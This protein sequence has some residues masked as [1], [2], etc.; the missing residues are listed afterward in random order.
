MRWEALFGD[1]EAQFEDAARDL[2]DDLVVDL[3]EAEMARAALSDRLR[4]RRGHPLTIRLVDGSDVRGVV[5]DAAPQWLLV[6]EGQR[7]V[8]VPL[9][10]VVAAWPL[11]EVAPEPGGVERR[12]RIGHALRALAREEARVVVRTMAGE[13]RG[14][15]LRV[16]LDHVDV[17]VEGPQVPGQA[18]SRA[19]VT[20]AL[21]HLLTVRTS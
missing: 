6:G 16:R 11:G 4:A 2:D 15:I 10:A 7:R 17:H 8:L 5:V 3:A 13:H 1:L 14:W 18:G 19:V 9:E 12:L 20:V 21:R